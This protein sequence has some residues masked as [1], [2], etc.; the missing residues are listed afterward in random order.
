MSTF[1]LS[2]KAESD[3]R[4]IWLYI[5]IDNEIA[6]DRL[7]DKM[8]QKFLLLADSPLIGVARDDLAPKSENSP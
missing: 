6:A 8:Y 1:H 2:N 3:L 5:A 7:L 4:E